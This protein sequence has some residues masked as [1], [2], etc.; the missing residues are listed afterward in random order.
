MRHDPEICQSQLDLAAQIDAKDRKGRVR[1][2]EDFFEEFETEH[3]F[4]C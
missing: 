4:P 3:G 1:N 2:A